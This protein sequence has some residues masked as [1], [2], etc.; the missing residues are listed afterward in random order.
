MFVF[1]GAVVYLILAPKGRED[2]AAL[3][4]SAAELLEPD[5][6]DDGDD[7][8][9]ETTPASETTSPVAT[10]DD[11]AEKADTAAIEEPHAEAG[12]VASEADAAK[13]APPEVEV[14]AAPE[15]DDAPE[16]EEEAT[17]ESA[18]DSAGG[19]GGPPAD[20]AEPPAH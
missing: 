2:P 9:P 5:S 12:A 20:E 1:I 17:V 15:S 7:A 16:V 4:G 8:A 10:A 11:V 3:S 6:I 19:D 14:A 18:E 13:V